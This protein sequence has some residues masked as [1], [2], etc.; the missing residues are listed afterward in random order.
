MPCSVA[1]PIGRHFRRLPSVR[2]QKMSR[3]QFSEIMP[4]SA[5]QSAIHLK[6][7]LSTTLASILYRLVYSTLV[8]PTA[9]IR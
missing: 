9:S 8:G 3:P 4:H 5:N 2:E 7:W 6:R 1:Q